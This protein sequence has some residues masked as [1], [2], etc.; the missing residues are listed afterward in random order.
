[1]TPHTIYFVRHGETEWNAERRWQGR[2]DSPLTDAGRE[3]ARSNADTL[4]A[5]VPD[6]RI[7]PFVSSP[8]GRARE[9]MRIVRRHMDLPCDGYSVDERLAELG[10][11]DWEGMTAREIRA[12]AP[13]EWDAFQ[14]APWDGAPC[15]GES[16]EQMAARLR[17]W[18]DELTGDIVA[19]A[20]GAVGRALRCMN[21]GLPVRE[22]PGFHATENDRVYRLSRGTEAVL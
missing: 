1:M 7:L 10:F 12:A 21:L 16:Y 18:V 22:M 19:V 20:H 3:H 4:L 2:K 13:A 11:G 6:V 14:A 15:G 9:T 5:S 8:L 17:S